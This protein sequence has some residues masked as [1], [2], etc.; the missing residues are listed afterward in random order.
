MLNKLDLPSVGE[1]LLKPGSEPISDLLLAFLRVF[2][3]RKTE[4]THWLRSDR[5]NDLKHIDC[6]LETVVEDNVRKFLLT[7]LLLLI[8]NYPTTLKVKVKR[9]T[10]CF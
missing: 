2:S 8:A 1:F 3:M 7:R 10:V 4:L 9:N 5:V 6:A